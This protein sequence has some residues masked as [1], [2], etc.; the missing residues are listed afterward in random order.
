MRHKGALLA[1]EDDARFEGLEFMPH[2]LGD[3][4]AI[5]DVLK[6]FRPFLR[7]ESIHVDAFAGHVEPRWLLRRSLTGHAIRQVL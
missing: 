6:T 3:V 2:V 4:D 1:F 5:D 7:P